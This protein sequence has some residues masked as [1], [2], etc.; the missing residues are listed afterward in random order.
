[1]CSAFATGRG[2]EAIRTA[3]DDSWPAHAFLLGHPRSGTTLLE[4]M[5]D[6]HPAVCSV[7]ESDIYSCVVEAAL[8]RGHTLEKET[9]RFAE[10]VRELPESQMNVRRQLY[11]SG[12]A[13]EAG[14]STSSLTLIDKNPALTASVAELARTMPMAR[15]VFM[16][17][18]PRDVCLSAYFQAIERTSW[19]VNWLT[20]EETVDQYVFAMDLWLRARP[21]LAQPWIE[22]RYEDVVCDPV[23]E[24]AKVT[25]FLG[26]Q[27]N[28]A[29]ADPAAHARGRI[30]KSPTHADVIQP[31]HQR[32]VGK[33]RRYEKYLQPFQSQLK[34]FVEAFGYDP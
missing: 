29:Q 10:Y 8:L 34:P 33:W 22:V 28:E 15:L 14:V 9:V 27:W 16:L 31:I 32:A 23:G 21:K 11:A 19:S 5:L 3:A 6:A 20:L 18:D 1:M 12:L 26:L 24:G 4:Q 2:P 7:E 17:R 13:R 30:V 25:D